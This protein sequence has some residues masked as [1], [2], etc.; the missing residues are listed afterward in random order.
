MDQRLWI[1]DVATRS[2]VSRDMP[3]ALRLNAECA[4]PVVMETAWPPE[5]RAV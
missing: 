3:G 1:E 4:A 5:D 2:A